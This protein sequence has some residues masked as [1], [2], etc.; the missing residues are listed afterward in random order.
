MMGKE[1]LIR[2][3]TNN[4]KKKKSRDLSTGVGVK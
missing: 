4:N 1:Y 3:I 2:D